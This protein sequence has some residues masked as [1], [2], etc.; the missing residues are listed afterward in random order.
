M[1]DEL[2]DDEPDL[3][4]HAGSVYDMLFSMQSD[5]RKQVTMDLWEL[6]VTRSIWVYYRGPDCAH[7]DAYVRFGSK[8]IVLSNITGRGR[9]AEVTRKGRMPVILDALRRINRNVRVECVV[10]YH[11]A[12]YLQGIGFTRRY[13]SVDWTKVYDE[14][15]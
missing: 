13:D 12:T 5:L 11:L 2:G 14:E 3:P 10:N 15:A 6:G 7:F 1:I 9:D 4:V 8:E